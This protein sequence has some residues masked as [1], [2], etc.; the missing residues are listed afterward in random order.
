M[1]SRFELDH[2]EKYINDEVSLISLMN[3]FL[4]VN[5]SKLIFLEKWK[6]SPPL[7]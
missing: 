4:D 3:S 6:K 2:D 7:E 1:A 5:T